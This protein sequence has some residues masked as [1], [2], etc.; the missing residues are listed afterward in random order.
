M[1]NMDDNTPTPQEREAIWD[2]L[3]HLLPVGNDP[4][5]QRGPV[6]AS[7]P[8]KHH[9]APPEQEKSASSVRQRQVADTVTLTQRAARRSKGNMHRNR[10]ET[11]WGPGWQM[12]SHAHL[13]VILVY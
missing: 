11:K 1:K 6:V 4:S 8:H 13:L 9:P 10:N 2:K 12:A 5:R 3:K 7:P